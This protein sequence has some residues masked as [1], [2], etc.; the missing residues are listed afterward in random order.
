MSGGEPFA[1]ELWEV[2][3]R[4]HV[5]GG[6][7]EIPASVVVLGN[8]TAGDAR[9]AAVRLAHI[10]ARVPAWRPCVRESWPYT[11]A[12]RTDTAELLARKIAG[13]MSPSTG[14]EHR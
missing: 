1:I 7:Y 11:S 5:V 8:G 6:R 2:T 12:V 14:E 10:R 13:V 4:A 9:L 3:T